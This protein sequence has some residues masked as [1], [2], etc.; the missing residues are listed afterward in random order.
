MTRP[1]RRPLHGHAYHGKTDAELLYIA[2]DAG[3]AA[4]AMR[5]H[6]AKAEAKYLDQLND[7]YTVLAYR[8]GVK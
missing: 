8:K 3:E 4:Q 7:A 5:H 1:T 6:D 2:K